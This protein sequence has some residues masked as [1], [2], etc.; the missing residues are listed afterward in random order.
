MNTITNTNHLTATTSSAPTRWLRLEGLAAFLGIIGLYAW[1]GYNGW[2]FLA[3]LLV[4][5]VSMLGYLRNPHLGALCYNL[6]HSYVL[7]LAL[8]S[9]ALAVGWIPGITVALIWTAHI[10]MD[11]AV[12]YG[13]KY[14][15]AFKDT[16]LGKLR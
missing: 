9:M 15:T 10:S 12:G 16:H 8:L 3:L 2:I 1:L 14:P 5:D 11:R 13:L 4:P 7:P 6:A